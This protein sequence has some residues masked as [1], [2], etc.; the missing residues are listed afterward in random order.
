MLTAAANT[1]FLVITN[2]FAEN[3]IISD[4]PPIATVSKAAVEIKK[5]SNL[6]KKKTTN[7]VE[8]VLFV[9]ILLARNKNP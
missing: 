4:F 9:Q 2:I 3:Q 5:L 1:S 8:K 6:A 7:F